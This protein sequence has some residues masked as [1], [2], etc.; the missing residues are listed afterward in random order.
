MIFKKLYPK[1]R[2]FEKNLRMNGNKIHFWVFNE[3]T[4]ELVIVYVSPNISPKVAIS[5]N[6][7]VRYT[8]AKTYERT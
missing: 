2:C 1:L 4:N 7:S 6:S 8:E 5:P 3:P